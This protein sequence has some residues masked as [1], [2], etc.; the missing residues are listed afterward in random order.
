MN[1]TAAVGAGLRTA[2]SPPRHSVLLRV[3]TRLLAKAERSYDEAIGGA[4]AV[5]L[6]LDRK[7]MPELYG[8]VEAEEIQR[9]ELQLRELC[10]TGWVRLVLA[11]EREFAGFV[12]RNP[13]L[14]LVD[15]EALASW[16]EF[17]RR[18]DRWQHKLVAHLT[19][20]WDAPAPESK[21]NLIEYLSRNP[22]A[23][24]SAVSVEEAMRSLQSLRELCVSGVSLPL[25]EASARVFHGRS[26]VLD[27]RDEFLRL[28]GAAPG[29]FWD[30]PIQLLV[31]IPAAFDEALFVENLVTFERMADLRR[32][33]WDRS[34][35][36][37]AAGFKGSAKRLRHRH[38]C[39]L[40]VR[41]VHGEA[42][43]LDA[44]AGRG[45]EAAGAWLF[46]RS[47]LPVRFFG[48]LDFAGMQILAS[49]R[50]VF[51]NA[52]AWKAGYGELNAILSCGGG[53][54]PNMASKERQTDPGTTGCDYADGVLLPSMRHHERFVDQEGFG[55]A[56]R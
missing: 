36:I 51:G 53:H 22:L 12:D 43:G 4:S 47:D 14:E 11:R 6:K 38:G 26:K 30:A 48:D 7:E 9:L 32:P 2:G 55:A 41:A 37:Y 40:Y 19:S 10:A 23:A 20:H 44:S 18:S 34:L 45:L 35:L 27:N 52:E 1:E 39:R 49:L 3:A 16:A 21:A 33:G 25:R 8:Q 29:Q 28:L 42:L 54:L 15:F 31:D 13:Q 50:E 46:G 24:L 17:Q 56:E 5:R